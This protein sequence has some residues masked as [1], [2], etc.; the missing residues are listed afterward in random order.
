YANGRVQNPSADLSGVMSGRLTR[1][2][3]LPHLG[4]DGRGALYMIF[5]HWTN[6]QPNEIY[7]F[8]STRLSGAGW[9]LPSKLSVSSG[10]NSQRA[11][12]TMDRAGSLLVAYSS[13]AR[14]PT[15]L[16][17]VQAHAMHYTVYLSALPKGE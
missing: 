6:A 13:A 3:E 17:T 1:Y 9:A 10:H 7:H 16:P 4:V 5:R 12:L 2:T 15:N 14:A 8:Y 11:S